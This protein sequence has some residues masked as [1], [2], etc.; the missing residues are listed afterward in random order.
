MTFPLFETIAIKN[1]EI[2]NIEL[3]QFRYEQSLAK[4]YANQPYFIFNLRSEIQHSYSLNE[5][6]VRCRISYN[7][8]NLDIHFF[9]YQKGKITTFKPIFCDEIDYELKFSDRNL[10]NQLYAKRGNCDEIMIIKKGWVTDCSI[11][12]L[13]FRKNNQWFTPSTPLLNGTKRQQLLIENRIIARE[14]KFIDLD[15]FEEIRLINA[16]NDLID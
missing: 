2:Q 11:G 6:L 3:H 7:A 5:K 4:Y 8:F 16:M 13:L 1:G 10:L 14:I 15:Y 12:N 9:P